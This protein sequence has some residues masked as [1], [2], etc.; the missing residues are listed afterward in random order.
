MGKETDRTQDTK[1]DKETD[2]PRDT[3]YGQGVCQIKGIT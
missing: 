3:K 1:M 2:R